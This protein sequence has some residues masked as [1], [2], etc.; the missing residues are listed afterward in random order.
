MRFFL[1]LL[2]ALALL[3]PGFCQSEGPTPTKPET[4]DAPHPAITPLPAV[5]F[6]NE[7]A[8][9]KVVMYHSLTCHHCSEFKLTKFPDFKKRYIDTGQVYFELKD[10]P[11]DDLSLK[12][13]VLC[14]TGRNVSTYLERSH[15]IIENANPEK[16][17]SVKFDWVN[18]EKPL[19]IIEK[20]L[21]PTGIPQ[22]S[23]QGDPSV[24][25]H[26]LEDSILQEA[27]KAGQDLHLNFAPGFTVNGKLI[28][29]QDLEK[30][31]AQAVADNG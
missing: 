7:R 19:E 16:N 14:W 6:G 31:V 29:S 22:E 30:T 8:P 21:E 13:A 12:C 23:Q 4:K 10:F 28:E 5:G 15:L 26:S 3:E 20:L 11:T 9:I 18:A 2:M 24:E 25:N 27:L 1:L 17:K